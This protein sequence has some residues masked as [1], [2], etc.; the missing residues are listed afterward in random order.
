ML[1]IASCTC[2]VYFDSLIIIVYILFVSTLT[3]ARTYER[4][5]THLQHNNKTTPP[6][7]YHFLDFAT[8]R[9]PLLTNF[10]TTT[11][12]RESKLNSRQPSL[13]LYST[14]SRLPVHLLTPLDIH[15]F[16]HWTSTTQCV[17]LP[18]AWV[19]WSYQDL[20][21]VLNLTLGTKTVSSVFASCSCHF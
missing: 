7:T 16:D 15:S 14:I 5:T 3:H 12:S 18:I 21:Q 10:Y 17:R 9:L 19:F 20:T 13:D 8:P 2:T 6:L 11:V 4:L 1:Y